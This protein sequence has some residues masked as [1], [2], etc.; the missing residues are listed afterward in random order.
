MPT[1]NQRSKAEAEHEISYWAE[2]QRK[3]LHLLALVVPFSMLAFGKSWSAAILVP[4][5]LLSLGADVLRAFSPGFRAWIDRWLGFMMRG[6]ERDVRPDVVVVNGAT[7]VLVTAALLI[8]IFPIQIAVFSFVMFLIS[9][10]A[11]ALYGRRFGKRRWPGTTRTLEGSIAFVLVG[12]LIV[13]AFPA[14]P[15]WAGAASVVVGAAAEIAHR[16]LNDNIRVPIA[17]AFTLF[18]LERFV[19]G[20]PVELIGF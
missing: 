12:L 9:D 11:A 10:A 7:W 5:S 20:L 8:V 19:L 4:L 15:F 13:L 1:P 17:A 14:V 6:E 2:V 18:L 16:P 3:A